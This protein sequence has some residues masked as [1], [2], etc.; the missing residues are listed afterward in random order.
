MKN[1]LGCTGL[2]GFTQLKNKVASQDWA[3]AALEIKNSKYCTDG[4]VF[5]F[6]VKELKKL[7]LLKFFSFCFDGEIFFPFT[8]YSWLS[9]C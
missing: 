1:S 3:G 9:M 2:M 5:S 4:N 7:I 6:G 8:C